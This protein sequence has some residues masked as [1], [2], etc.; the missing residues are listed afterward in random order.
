MRTDFDTLEVYNG[1]ELATR[2][3]TERV[4]EDWFALLNVGKRMAAT[5]ISDSHRIQYQWAGY[6]RTFALVDPQRR[7]RHRPADRHEG[8]RRRDQ[9]GTELRLERPA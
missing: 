7:G 5:G 4:L 2:E 8:G 1:Y 9:E 3:L 6:P